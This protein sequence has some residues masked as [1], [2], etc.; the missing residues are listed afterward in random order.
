MLKKYS[1]SKNVYLYLLEVTGKY[2]FIICFLVFLQAIL[3]GCG[4]VFALV[5]RNLINAATLIQRELFVKSAL[6]LLIIVI[7]RL[8]FLYLFRICNEYT[9]S[10]VENRCKQRLYENLLKKDFHSIAE[11][12]SA[13]WMNYLTSDCQTV[14]NHIVEILPGLVGMSVQLFS[15]C[16]VLILLEPLLL[17]IIIPAAVLLLFFSTIFRKQMKRLHKEI[18][19]ADGELRVV[20][21]ESLSGMTMIRALAAEKMILNKVVNKMDLH[22]NSR[23]RRISFSSFCYLG[24][25]FL[26][27]GGYWA[28]AIFCGY[29][30]LKGTMTVGGLVAV[31]QL[32][33][34]VQ[35]PMGNISSFIPR[36]YAMLASAE[37]LI[38][39][40]NFADQTDEESKKNSFTLS[41]YKNE[42]ESINLSHIYFAYPNE[43]KTLLKDYSLSIHKGEVIAFTGQ[44]GCGKST[45]FRILLSL[46]SPQKGSCFLSD[47]NG[48]HYSMKQY[49]RIFSYVPQGK[50][51]MT[52][53][54]RNIVCFSES[55]QDYSDEEIWSSLNISCAEDFVRK[56][57][58]QLDTVLG[59]QGIGLS[60]G[61][62]QRLSMARAIL[63]KRPILLLDEATSALDEKTE[64]QLLQNLKNLNDRTILLVTHRPAALSICNRVI[65]FE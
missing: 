61:Q 55:E 51:F 32:I 7:I 46:Y 18:Q 35:G 52:G 21:Q 2:G 11:V 60:E 47:K 48:K 62:L 34:Q 58:R 22:R 5:F 6:L 12:H 30:I 41:F 15:A 65:N 59:E 63:S 20:L 23:M 8:V 10:M 38:E 45:I 37:R 33:G 19:E 44:S 64:F 13:K 25:G 3:G 4:V 24:F 9:K 56:L 53:S 31:I 42:F 36:F 43:E 17:W 26:M 29:R 40:E 16:I 14:A 1:G 54:V 50:F 27:Q 39:P 28:S 57:P 49:Q